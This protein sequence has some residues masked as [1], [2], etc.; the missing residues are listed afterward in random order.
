MAAA[1][2]ACRVPTE[3]CAMGTAS[4]TTASIDALDHVQRHHAAAASEATTQQAGLLL[5][6]LRAWRT[7]ERI[8]QTDSTHDPTQEGS[9]L[10]AF[11]RGRHR[12]VKWMGFFFL[13]L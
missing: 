4:H 13:R 2:M 1:T 9:R 5:N 7:I 3:V 8:V 11:L 12:K 10:P 6:L